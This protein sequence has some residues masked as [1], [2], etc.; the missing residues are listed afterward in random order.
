MVLQI[1][2]FYTK[3]F[4]LIKYRPFNNRPAQNGFLKSFTCPPWINL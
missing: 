4:V 1:P 3:S 2:S